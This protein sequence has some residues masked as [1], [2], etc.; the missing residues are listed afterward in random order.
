M[1]LTRS[2]GSRP[3]VA[4][5]FMLFSMLLLLAAPGRGA[6]PAMSKQALVTLL[7]TQEGIFSPREIARQIELRG[8]AFQLQPETDQ[9]LRKLGAG[10]SVIQ[11]V[12]KNYRAP[13][14]GGTPDGPLTKGA[15]LKLLGE[16]RGNEETLRLVDKR[17]V[18]FIMTPE[19]GAE[20]SK[21]GADRALL[22]AIAAA[23][24]EPGPSYDDLIAEANAA[25]TARQYDKAVETLRRAAKLDPDS[26]IA[27]EYL[28]VIELNAIPSRKTFSPK[29]VIEAGKQDARRAIELG[30]EA[31]FAVDH[32]A[33]TGLLMNAYGDSGFLFV[34]KASLAYIR[35]AKL[36]RKS[37]DDSFDVE[38]ADV[39]LLK[40]WTF[41]LAFAKV[42]IQGGEVKSFQFRCQPHGNL[43]KFIET[44]FTEFK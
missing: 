20:I 15:I 25:A 10:D 37:R 38:R 12:G 22:G 21:L 18:D 4:C 44:L 19:T 27:Y 29:D 5:W 8:V 23:F 3:F 33:G 40:S 1:P 32:L 28:T 43:P 30:G 35:L 24:K 6:S 2:L 36:S 14:E 16:K 26:A 39:L 42:K 13:A 17:G 11:A 9:E 41:N 31:A 34:R 7:S